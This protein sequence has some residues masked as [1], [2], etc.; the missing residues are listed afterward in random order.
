MMMCRPLL[1]AV[2][3]LCAL[4]AFAQEAPPPG[5]PPTGPMKMIRIG[6]LTDMS[7]NM[8]FASGKGSVE[9]AQMAVDDFYAK[10]PKM[11]PAVLLTADY[12]SRLDLARHISDDWLDKQQV[13]AI[14]DVPSSSIAAHLQDIMRARG[15][16]L[17]SCP[18]KDNMCAP[19]SLS[20]L[21]GQDV[22]NKN[23]IHALLLENKKNWFVVSSDDAYSQNM[24]NS[25]KKQIESFGGKVI[26]EAQLPRRLTGMETV[27]AQV[28]PDAT[29]VIFMA[30]DRHDQMFLMK[31]WPEFKKPLPPFVFSAI[32]LSDM[33]RLPAAIPTFYSI[34]P[35]YWNQDEA[36]RAWSEQFASHNQGSMPTGIHAAVY[37]EVTH[38][39]KTI[40]DNGLQPPAQLLTSMKSEAL[41]TRLFG[42]SRIR[43]DGVLMHHLH[44]LMTKPVAARASRWDVFN[45]VRTLAPNDVIL[46]AEAKC[47]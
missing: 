32:F 28:R 1:T 12:Q 15:V 13:N 7:G 29:D 26:G 47:E 10:Q 21:Y 25:A 3:C 23:I 36:T 18:A 22:L 24:A 37:S 30:F 19:T 40:Q 14:V 35:F 31:R 27:L 46:P 9:A 33:E 17:S 6:V 42:P 43:A 39:L 4:P 2:F 16:L 41:D 44:L 5:A 45:V 8:A 34:A 38:Y 20:W 11:P